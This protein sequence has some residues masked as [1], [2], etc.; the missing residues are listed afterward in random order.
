MCVLQ[1]QRDYKSRH[2]AAGSR[3]PK[4]GTHVGAHEGESLR[5][6]PTMKVETYSCD[7]C[8]RMRGPGNHW[9]LVTLSG[10]HFILEPWQGST[11]ET[12]RSADQHLCGEACV[13][14]SAGVF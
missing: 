13:C 6:E 7:V 12:I 1:R 2:E 4:P 5:C 8:G 11:E 14:K 9:W 3:R 10:R